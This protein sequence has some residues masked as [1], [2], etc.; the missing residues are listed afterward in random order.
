MCV[1][2]HHSQVQNAKWAISGPKQDFVWFN[3]APCV[4]LSHLCHLFLCKFSTL[5]LFFALLMP[6]PVYLYL[7][8]FPHVLCRFPCASL[9]GCD[10]HLHHWTVLVQ[11]SIGLVSVCGS[12]TSLWRAR[13]WQFCERR[14]V[15]GICFFLFGWNFHDFWLEGFWWWRE[16]STSWGLIWIEVLQCKSKK[17]GKSWDCSWRKLQKRINLH[18]IYNWKLTLDET[19]I[20]STVSTDTIDLRVVIQKV[21]TPVQVN[22]GPAAIHQTRV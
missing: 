18:F 17:I 15:S 11:V 14:V 4:C 3:A 13:N 7:A 5:D 20:T 12:Q 19:Y 10:P 8:H 16:K 6:L 9:R 1:C 22:K 21:P 2:V